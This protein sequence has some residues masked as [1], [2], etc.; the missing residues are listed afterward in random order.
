MKEESM[1]RS[2]SAKLPSLEMERIEMPLL[3]SRFSSWVMLLISV[4]LLEEVDLLGPIWEI[5]LGPMDRIWSIK[6]LLEI[7]KDRTIKEVPISE[8]N[9]IKE[10]PIS[11]IN[12]I[13]E[14]QISEIN[15]IR[16]VPIS[17]INLIK[18]VPISDKVIC[19][20]ILST[21]QIDL[22]DKMDK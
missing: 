9:P 5:K 6:G 20:S 7:I 12:L 22:L 19:L 16:E 10:E 3:L 21:K 18:E 14:V 1:T 13:K 8:I 17:E 15:P 11:E 4:L 2:D